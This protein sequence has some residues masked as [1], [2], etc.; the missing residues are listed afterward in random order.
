M[1]VDIPNFAV[2]PY[3]ALRGYAVEWAGPDSLIVSRGN[4]LFSCDLAGAAMRP[5]GTFPRPTLR[6]AVARV[7][8]GQRLLRE[9]YYNVVPL[10][11]GRLFTTYA[12]DIAVIERGRSHSIVGIRRP[13]RVLRGGCA[14][15]S[16]GCVY[17][18]EYFANTSRGEMYVYRLS[19][20]GMRA[21]V[22]YVFPPGSIYHIHGVRR[23]PVEDNFLCMTGDRRS[24]CRFLRTRDRFATVE[25]IGEGSEDWRFVSVVPREQDWLAATDAEFRQNE[26]VRIDRQS[27]ERTWLADVNGPVYY[28]AQVGDVAFFGSTAERCV[29]Q[30]EP[31]ASLYAVRGTTVSTVLTFR[32]DISDARWAWRYFMPGTLHFPSNGGVNNTLF[33]SGVALRGFDA[34]VLRVTW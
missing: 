24:E 14:L 20:E 25:A 15:G 21:E 29:I 3:D 17:W 7:R 23:D 32:K 31:R 10:P 13:A 12:M 6:C 34:R 18:G 2:T 5:V 28:S 27:G 16:D 11:D 4:S 22:V 1:S 19:P 30:T 33:V 26:I 8:L 9:M